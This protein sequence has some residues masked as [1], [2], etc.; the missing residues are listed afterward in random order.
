MAYTIE[1]AYGSGNLTEFID[2]SNL[3]QIGLKVCEK[4]EEDESSRAE[5]IENQRDWLKL[6]AQVRETKSYP[7]ENASNVKYPLMTVA[8]MQFHARALPSLIPSD[9]PVMAKVVGEDPTGEKARRAERV[10]KYMSYQV[11][12]EMEEWIDD[13]DR[14]LLVLPVI[15]LAYKKTYYDETKQRMKSDLLLPTECIVN[16]HAT[17]YDRARVTHKIMMDSN[18]VVELQRGEIF[19]DVDLQA[20]LEMNADRTRDETLGFT[21]SNS[22]D[23][24]YEILEIHDWYDLD[25]DGYKEPY[26]ITIEKDSKQVLRILPRWATED[27]V[28]Y[29]DEGDIVRIIPENYFTPYRFIPDPNSGV[30]GLGFGTLLGP[31]NHAVN[32]LINQ[33]IDAGTLSVMQSGFIGRGA[34]LKAG[35]TRFRPGEWKIVNTTGDDLRKSVFPM[36]VRD[37][38]STL[39]S[40]LQL[41]I[42]SGERIS[43]VSD[44]MLGENPGQ[45]QPATTSMTVLEQGLKVFT[46]IYKRIHRSLSKEFKLIYSMDYEYL[47][48]EL[49]R[50]ILDVE[51]NPE[52]F[53]QIQPTPEQVAQ[54]RQGLER[55]REQ[56]SREDFTPSG[57]D[58]IPTSDPNMVSDSQKILKARSLLEKVQMGLP[59]NV[60]VVTKKVLESENHDN[61]MELMNIPPPP[62]TIEQQ[63]FDLDVLKEKR[64]AMNSYFDNIKKVA[65]AESLEVGQQFEIY[66][67]LVDDYVKV[68]T[69]GRDLTQNDAETNTGQTN[70]TGA[71]A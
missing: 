52:G 2:D 11:L 39:F 5:W 10:G 48:E 32:T 35:A 20:P 44:I 64:E 63:Q 68:A 60:Q 40:L 47:D 55:E 38:S 18:E 22:R 3:E 25:E 28:I 7:W 1:D 51:I 37:P 4:V 34:K 58:I 45:N 46:G 23:D 70:N 29:N 57:I 62:P 71:T 43:A 6:A 26:I 21:R 9:R 65:E 42:E 13:L 15:G 33:L 61:I 66:R 31:T 27:S 14:L 69:A 12:E 30:Y 16:Y 8:C 41:L 53:G 56:A 50:S 24:P 67:G 36:P 59:L 17:D 49:Y 54:V 19:R